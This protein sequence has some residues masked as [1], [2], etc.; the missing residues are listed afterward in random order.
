[1]PA[2]IRP[3]KD[4]EG[5]GSGLGWCAKQFPGRVNAARNGWI[6]VDMPY[7]TDTAKHS[8]IHT[9]MFRHDKACQSGMQDALMGACTLFILF[10]GEGRAGMKDQNLSVDV[11]LVEIDQ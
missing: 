4:S 2:S 1:M 8:R 11:V 5:S 3:V 10:Q 7:N 9:G 6:A